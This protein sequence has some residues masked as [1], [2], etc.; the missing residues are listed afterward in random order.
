MPFLKK[1]EENT[2]VFD[3]SSDEEPALDV[4]AGGDDFGW[5][6]KLL[7]DDVDDSDEVVVVG[8]IKSKS[9]KVTANKNCEDD[10][11]C[12]ILDGDPDKP[13]AVDED[14]ADDGDDLVIVCQKGQVYSV[15]FYVYVK[16]LFLFVVERREKIVIVIEF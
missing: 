10:D 5:L 11:D 7:C 15:K 1:M 3:I 9:S 6:T 13:V 16:A 8:E 12:V 4:A 14:K 2:V